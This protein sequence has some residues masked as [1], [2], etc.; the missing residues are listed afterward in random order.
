M[1]SFTKVSVVAMSLAA[2]MTSALKESEPELYGDDINALYSYYYD[3]SYYGGQ[4][5]VAIIF[6]DVLLLICILI[7]IVM[8]IV[9]ACRRRH[10]GGHHEA[11]HN[12]HYDPHCTDG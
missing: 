5:T 4:T 6:L 1:E 2:A 11:H 12:P 9:R 3:Y 10:H 8:C 7:L